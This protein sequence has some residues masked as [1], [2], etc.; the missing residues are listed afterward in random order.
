MTLNAV[1]EQFR[2]IAAK[3]GNEVVRS[4]K[5]GPSRM[6]NYN[7]VPHAFFREQSDRGA[8][9]EVGSG[10]GNGCERC[11]RPLNPEAIRLD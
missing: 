6:L 8:A 5:T 2:E 11:A 4:G 1:L 10:V 9:Q 7:L 3:L